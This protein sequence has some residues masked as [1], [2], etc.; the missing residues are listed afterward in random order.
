MKKF[1]MGVLGAIIIS[2]P[3][4]ISAPA[5]AQASQKWVAIAI[6]KAGRVHHTRASSQQKI[7][8]WIRRKCSGCGV[9][10][11][12]A[13]NYMAIIRCPYDNKGTKESFGYYSGTSI[14]DAV[15]KAIRK[16]KYMLST[17]GYNV[18][19]KQCTIPIAYGKGRFPRNPRF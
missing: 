19:T 2:F 10:Y 9:V 11:T 17:A 13:K 4:A 15:T 12:E 5:T 18:R 7:K 6:D 16:L 14:K 1:V 8:V 3:M